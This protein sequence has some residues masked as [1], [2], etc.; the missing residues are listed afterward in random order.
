MMPI[1]WHLPGYRMHA[2]TALSFDEAELA[3]ALDAMNAAEL[4][5]LSFGVIGFDAAGIV[6]RYNRHESEAA[7]LGTARVLEHALFTEVAP[8]MNNYLV[9]QRFVDAT[10][11]G[12]VLDVVIDYVLT[13]RMRPTRV[14]L[15]LLSTPRHHY[16]YVLVMRAA[17]R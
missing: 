4:D 16:A 14:K 8:C 6:R 7:G 11:A 2:S 10:Q 17:G 1:H 3:S 13:L 12:Q 9:A 5:E 15:R